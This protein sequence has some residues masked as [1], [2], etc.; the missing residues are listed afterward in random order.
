MEQG[1]EGTYSEKDF[2]HN[3]IGK[4]TSHEYDYAKGYRHLLYHST[5]LHKSGEAKL[6]FY[7]KCVTLT[8]H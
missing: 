2:W 4:L 6:V 8:N 7:R 1:G 5:L 3:P